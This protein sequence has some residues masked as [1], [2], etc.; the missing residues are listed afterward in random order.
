MEVYPLLSVII[1]V[2]NNELTL[3]ECID[4]VIKQTYTNIEIIIINDGSTDNSIGII[5]SFKE[6]YDNI[7]FIDS[8]NKGVSHARNL[9][10][11]KSSG[12]YIAFVDG[13]DLVEPNMYKVLIEYYITREDCAFISCGFNSKMSFEN[14]THFNCVPVCK[15]IDDLFLDDSVQGFVWNKLYKREYIKELF[16]DTSI[17]AHEDLLFNY[18]LL[19]SFPKFYHVDLELYHYRINE[20][21]TMFSKHFSLS[22]MS[23]MTVYEKILQDF[24]NESMSKKTVEAHYVLVCLIL[25]SNILSDKKLNKKDVLLSNLYS[26]VNCYKSSFESLK[27]YSLK[28]RISCKLIKINPKLFE[29]IFKI[30]NH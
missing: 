7:I 5:N 1:P 20:N 13:D 9:G 10:L 3:S 26:V 21:G 22:K 25:I 15:K 17:F 6:N 24:K 30:I 29:F 27:R 19:K 4:S 28:Y 14:K 16:F 18:Y 11:K 23:A 12:E 8:D 2:Y